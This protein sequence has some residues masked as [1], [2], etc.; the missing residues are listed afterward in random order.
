M[1]IDFLILMKPELSVTL[2][3]FIIL[4]LKIGNKEWKNESLLRV[5]NVLLFINVL[6]GFFYNNEGSLFGDMFHTNHLLAFEKNTL[7]LGTLI[8]SLQSHHWLK[9]HRV[10]F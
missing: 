5:I 8:I 10:L 4:F 9:Q 7:N 3:L 2:I 1:P 6:V